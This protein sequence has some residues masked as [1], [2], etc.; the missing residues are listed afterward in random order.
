M[1]AQTAV[2]CVLLAYIIL[3]IICLPVLCGNQRLKNAYFVESLMTLITHSIASHR[4]TIKSNFSTA[5]D[6]ERNLIFFRF[7][8]R[9]GNYL[10]Y[11]FYQAFFIFYGSSSVLF[12]GLGRCSCCLF[13]SSAQGNQCGSYA[14]CYKSLYLQYWTSSFS[15]KRCFKRNTPK[16]RYFS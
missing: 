6:T 4:E 1:T 16:C 5:Q 11:N 9:L 7:Q 10:M 3:Y 2:D 14:G 12:G 13:F 8:R 15:S